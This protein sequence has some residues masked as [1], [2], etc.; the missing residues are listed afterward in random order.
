MEATPGRVPEPKP[1]TSADFIPPP[2]PKTEPVVKEVPLSAPLPP[3]VPAP[4]EIHTLNAV[5]TAQIVDQLLELLDLQV[6]KNRI[7]ESGRD[8]TDG[9]Y[10]SIKVDRFFSNRGTDY[11]VA[12]GVTDPFNLTLLRL[13]E[14]AGT[15]VVTLQPGESLASIAGKILDKLQWPYTFGKQQLKLSPA[16]DQVT[17]ID[18]LMLVTGGTSP[19]QLLITDKP[20]PKPEAPASG[21]GGP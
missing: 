15:Q 19:R 11:I 18:G 5:D 21:K 12:I 20:L 17:E 16:S 14:V 10:I 1:A 4:V 2:P 3:V 7:V 13:L 9:T 8:N 6:T